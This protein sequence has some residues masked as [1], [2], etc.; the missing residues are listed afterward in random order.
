[1]KS[2][3]DLFMTPLEKRGI[4]NARINLIPKASGKILEIGA[5]TGANLK[6]YNFNNVD[7]LIVTDKKI[8]K[9]L[10]KSK[11]E[12]IQFMESNVSSLPFDDNT[13]DYIVHTLVFCSV[14]NVDKGLSELR[15]V[16]KKDG[17]LIFIEHIYPEKKRLKRL[18]SFLNPAWRV[19]AS[20]CNLNRDYEKSLRS[21]GFDIIHSNK[22]MNTV[23]VSGEAKLSK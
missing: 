3:Y 10:I 12:L 13:F 20:G 19:V 6:Y 4:R 9:V 7:S 5:G 14:K 2:L 16:L 23:F 11:K 22:F 8:N 15:R 1:M 21:N 18:F 17:T